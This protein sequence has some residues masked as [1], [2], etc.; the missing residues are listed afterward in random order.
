MPACGSGAPATP[1]T[2]ALT[3]RPRQ[4]SLLNLEEVLIHHP[5][6]ASVQWTP[7]GHLPTTPSARVTPMNIAII[8]FASP[9]NSS[10]ILSSV[11][12]TP[13][14]EIASCCGSD[15]M[16]WLHAVSVGIDTIQNDPALTV[17]Q[18]RDIL[19]NNAAR[20]LRLKK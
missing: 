3:Y 14:S 2:I 15:K 8:D 19:Y 6:L 16:V 18:K 10:T 7:G 12:S 4:S 11:L 9:A 1:S 13:D 17:E 5:K 20:F